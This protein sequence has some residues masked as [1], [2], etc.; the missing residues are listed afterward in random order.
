MI[1]I[2]DIV[3]PRPEVLKDEIQGIIR[4]YKIGDAQRIE[5]DAERFFGSTYPSNALKNVL[6]R[7]DDKLTYN[8]HRGGFILQGPRGSG[9]SHALVTL[10]H[11]FHEPQIAQSWFERWNIA[12]KLPE[13][14]KS[15]ILSTRQT[16]PAYL[17]EPIFERAGRKDLL[18]KIDKYPT[19][20]VIEDLVRDKTVAIFLDEV[21]SWWKTFEGKDYARERNKFFI[22]NLLNVAGDKDYQL[23]VFISTYGVVE[24]LEPSFNRTNPYREDMDSSGDQEK[25]IFHRLFTKPREDIDERQVRVVIRAYTEK[26]KAPIQIENLKRYQEECVRVYPFHP[27]LLSVLGDIYEGE[28]GTGSVRGQ[29]NVLSDLVKEH[30][31]HT[32]LF[33]LSDLNQRAFRGIDRELVNKC[34]K[35][36]EKRTGNIDYGE[37]ILK[38]ILLYSLK[39]KPATEH[40]ILLGVYKPSHGMSLTQLDMSLHNLYGQAY[41][42]HKKNESYQIKKIEALN[43]MISRERKQVTNLDFKTKLKELVK[44][45][46]FDNR[47]FLFEFDQEDIPDDANHLKFV[48]MLKHYDRDTQLEQEID[49]F[50]R[51]KMYQDNFVFI[52][53]KNGGP[54]EDAN[55][56]LKIKSI[57]AAE[58]LLE[59]LEEERED[60]Q[61]RIQEDKREAVQY[62]R[63]LYG[64]WVKWGTRPDTHEVA[65]ILINVNPDIRDIR[66]KIRTDRDTLKS[67]IL[68]IIKG[69]ERGREIGSLLGD[70]Q[71]RRSLTLISSPNIF[72][73]VI[74]E[75]HRDEIMIVGDRAK[76]YWNITP[77]DIQDDWKIIDID[78]ATPP[79]PID[80]PDTPP[81]V[82]DEPGSLEIEPQ[83]RTLINTREA[84]GNS[85]RSILNKYEMILNEDTLEAVLSLRLEIEFT[86]LSKTQLLEFLRDLPTGDIEQWISVMNAEVKWSEYED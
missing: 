56:Q 8:S 84:R 16:E 9:K 80:V 37:G 28:R 31:Q 59:G 51:G 76:Q 69:S 74:K 63:A 81:A 77:H 34:G 83:K 27:Q 2:K 42:L 66:D 73:D 61:K 70:F 62:L 55:L 3:Q 25:V 6:D 54:L 38:V 78:Y 26:Y 79:E 20:E 15:V 35:D 64:K 17:W 19:T 47:V 30:Y 49:K 50:L 32:D 40:E 45:V 21:E 18:E 71:K 68:N 58:N 46:L 60:L 5:S 52:T 7:I 29:M 53:P 23:F 65:P 33:L 85:P 1:K 86:E 44:K 12:S 13:K 41:Y 11:I 67:E 14:S 24:G 4:P 57:C 43:A 22:E 36:M 10:Y 82:S 75:M 48:V 72:Y 39:G